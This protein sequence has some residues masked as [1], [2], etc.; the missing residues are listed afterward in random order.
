L[1]TNIDPETSPDRKETRESGFFCG[2]VIV[3]LVCCRP[4][5]DGVGKQ[6]AKADSMPTRYVA[7]RT[8]YSFGKPL[9]YGRFELGYA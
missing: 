4:F 1:G 9:T 8:V 3:Y 2:R 7:D 6:A 5:E